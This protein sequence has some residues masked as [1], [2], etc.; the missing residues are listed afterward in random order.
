MKNKNIQNWARII[1]ESVDSIIDKSVENNSVNENLMSS[2]HSFIDGFAHEIGLNEDNDNKVQDIK[3]EM[4]EFMSKIKTKEDLQKFIKEY[5]SKID[6]LDN[7]SNISIIVKKYLYKIWKVLKYVLKMGSF[8]VANIQS[9]AILAAVV[10][11]C[12]KFDVG[13]IEAV[14]KAWNAA[15][16][17]YK[18]ANVTI[19]TAGKSIDTYKSIQDKGIDI[20]DKV[21]SALGRLLPN[22]F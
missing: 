16:V 21:G 3:N 6:N 14:Q 18:A 5:Q 19:D 22:V 20:G 12:Y 9:L 7:N 2:I 15:K 13:P 10:F 1:D 11:V 4:Y 17:I 8:V